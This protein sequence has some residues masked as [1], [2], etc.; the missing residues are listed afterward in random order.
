M[1]DFTNLSELCEDAETPREYPFTEIKGQP[2]LM[3]LPATSANER[4]NNARLKGIGKRT[5]GG[6]KQLKINDATVKA[7]RD[8]DRK[9]FA[10]YC[11]TG[12]KV[13]PVD[14]TGAEVPFSRQ[15]VYEFFCAIPDWM[16]DDYR[17]WVQEPMNFT[18]DA[19]ELGGE[20]EDTL[21]ELGNS[22]DVIQPG[23]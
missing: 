3:S 9:L 12:W 18:G 7:A 15:N 23:A 5:N 10:Q 4:F 2:T 22:S 1:V 16:F 14:A 8:E 11:A 6:R 20:E 17:T 19:D 21:E 13:P